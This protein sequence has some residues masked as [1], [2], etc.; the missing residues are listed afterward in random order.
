METLVIHIWKV[1]FLVIEVVA[2][3]VRSAMYQSHHLPIHLSSIELELLVFLHLHNSGIL[4]PG[5][6]Q[7]SLLELHLSQLFDW[8]YLKMT[9]LSDD[10]YSLEIDLEIHMYQVYPYILETPEIVEILLMS[11]MILETC[12]S[13]KHRRDLCHHWEILYQSRASLVL[14]IKQL[15][16]LSSSCNSL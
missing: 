6:I 1:D 4:T 9:S 2:S 13:K 5:S 11:V 3:L 10:L 12:H 7:Q 15:L 8:L 16:S 14:D